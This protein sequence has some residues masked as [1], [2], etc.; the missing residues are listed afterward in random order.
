[1]PCSRGPALGSG[2]KIAHYLESRTGP[3]PAVGCRVTAVSTGLR[4]RRRPPSCNADPLSLWRVG[5]KRI[6]MPTTPQKS[7]VK[8]SRYDLASQ[9]DPLHLAPAHSPPGVQRT[10]GRALSPRSWPTGACAPAQPSQ[11]E[12][13]R[14]RLHGAPQ[15]HCTQRS[16]RSGLRSCWGQWQGPFTRNAREVP[17]LLEPF[18]GAG[19]TRVCLA[20][21]VWA[22]RGA[23][24]CPA[25]TAPCSELP[26]P[27]ILTF[28]KL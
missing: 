14:C 11:Q 20:L 25:A 23:R 19:A 18:P 17:S 10:P 5:E 28:S 2:G 8:I 15:P 27:G 26:F 16:L 9:R 4:H 24:H 6:K 12:G 1:M 7:S 13:R 21:A 3:S 22:W